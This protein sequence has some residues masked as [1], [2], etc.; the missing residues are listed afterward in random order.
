M[1]WRMLMKRVPSRS[2]TVVGDIAQ[3]GSLSGARSWADVFDGWAAGRWRVEELTVNYRT[4]AQVMEVA[5][6]VLAVAR[7]GAVVPVSARI[8]DWAPVA[9][10]YAT[11]DTVVDVVRGELDRFATV[12]VIAPDDLVETTRVALAAGLPDGAVGPDAPVSVLEV[13]AAKGLEFD[14][15]VLLEPAQIL[16]A[17][18]RGA[19]DIYVAMTRPTQRLVVLHSEPLPDMLRALPEES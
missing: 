18:P 15:V 8:G 10:P 9:I 6:D 2:M 17:S 13:T 19:S 11:S 3:T 4:P 7:P 1:Q 14:A 12:A 5:A 16:A